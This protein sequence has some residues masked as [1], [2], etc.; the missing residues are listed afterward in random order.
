MS[1]KINKSGFGAI[2]TGALMLGATFSAHA[3]PVVTE[4]ALVV[5]ASGSISSSEWT[6]QVKGY[7]A[8]ITA[9]L[10]TDGKVAVSVIRF[11]ETAS[12]VRGMTLI[13]S[14][15]AR[16][17]LAN[18]F[19]DGT[20][21]LLQSGNGNLT[22]ISCGIEYA[23]GTLGNS[24]LWDAGRRI[25]DVSTDGAWNVGVDPN[26]GP[27]LVGTSE[28]AVANEASVVNAIGIAV[29]PDFAHGP[30]S[31]SIV[32]GDFDDF[33]DSLKLK[34]AKELG[35]GPGCDEETTCN[36]DDIPEP[37]TLALFGLGLAGLGFAR[38]R[39]VA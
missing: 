35:P 34:L 25:I 4:L 3:M 29:I 15:A 16:D 36:P 6:T 31:F 26:G 30:D 1:I 22:C 20:N 8:A 2:I 18:F 27:G 11:G 17:D 24:L 7:S 5:D 28:W 32:A 21:E 37:G 13:D 14:A 10:P 39:K 38:R 19:W 9:I 23:E 12:V 33:E